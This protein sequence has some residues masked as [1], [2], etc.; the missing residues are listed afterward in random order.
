MLKMTKKFAT[1]LVFFFL[2]KIAVR[3]ELRAVA[4]ADSLPDFLVSQSCVL[5]D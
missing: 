3:L 2:K 1:F 5:D 4:V